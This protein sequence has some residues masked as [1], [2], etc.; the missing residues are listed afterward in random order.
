MQQFGD[1]R[2]FWLVVRQGTEGIPLVVKRRGH[3][4]QLA[5]GVFAGRCQQSRQLGRGICIAD[6]KLPQ[7]VAVRFKLLDMCGQFAQQRFEGQV[8]Q[9]AVRYNDQGFRQV[10]KCLQRCKGLLVQSMGRARVCFRE[11][12]YLGA[13]GTG[14]SLYDNTTFLVYVFILGATTASFYGWLPLYLPE[15][16]ATKVRATGQGFGFNFG[17]IIAAI[18]ALNTGA[19]TTMF[20]EPVSFLGLTFRPGYS[21]AC[22]AISFIYLA[23]LALIWLAPE[24]GGKDLPE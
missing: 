24:T 2:S 12:C 7:Q 6:L 19:L 23:G 4:Q 1:R 22:T 17:R 10:Y 13:T 14:V 3:G 18:G 11:E 8:R 16:F 21:G 15:L 20:V 5:R 9:D